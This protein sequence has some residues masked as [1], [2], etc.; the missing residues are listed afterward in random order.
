V[1]ALF[2]TL[3]RGFGCI[4]GRIKTLIWVKGGKGGPSYGGTGVQGLGG[5]G[6]WAITE[7][8]LGARGGIFPGGNPF[9]GGPGNKSPKPFKEGG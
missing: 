7:G 1:V 9:F 6:E 2:R 4:G 5:E 8:F 3:E